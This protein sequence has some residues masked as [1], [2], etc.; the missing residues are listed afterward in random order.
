MA[1]NVAGHN[2]ISRLQ[3]AILHALAAEAGPVP[4]SAILGRLTDAPPTAARR[5]SLS[6]ALGRLHVRGLI[7]AYAPEVCRPGKGMLRSA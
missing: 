5:A 3:K 4:P 2:G 6:K 7:V 1:N